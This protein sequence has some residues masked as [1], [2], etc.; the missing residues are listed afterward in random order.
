MSVRTEPYH[1][2]QHCNQGEAHRSEDVDPSLH[3]FSATFRFGRQLCL[4]QMTLE[5]LMLFPLQPSG[6]GANG[7]GNNTADNP[8]L[9]TSPVRLPD[10]EKE[11]PAVETPEREYRR[12]KP[13]EGQ[14]QRFFPAFRFRVILPV[15][16]HGVIYAVLAAPMPHSTRPTPTQSRR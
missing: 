15:I 7:Y 10:K 14:H 13:D 9:A 5:I 4:S 12:S 2:E 1:D 3:R 6:V 11:Q 8:D 16:D